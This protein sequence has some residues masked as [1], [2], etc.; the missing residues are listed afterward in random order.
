MADG[1]INAFKWLAAAAAA[2]KTELQK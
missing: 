1:L 2:A